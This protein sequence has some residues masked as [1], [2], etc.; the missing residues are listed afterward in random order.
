MKIAVAM[1]H[2]SIATT[3]HTV[4]HWQSVHCH[5]IH[6]LS[7]SIGIQPTS[8]DQ[9][10]LCDPPALRDLVVVLRGVDWHQLGTQLPVPREKLNKID[11][12][13]HDT[14]RKLNETL[15]YWLK[16]DKPS[17]EKVIEALE[18]IGD[19]RN[20]VIE[21]RSKYCRV[22]LNSLTSSVAAMSVNGKQ[23]MSEVRLTNLSI[24]CILLM[25]VV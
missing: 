25:R 5:P 1:M 6:I 11:E 22:P 7:A 2:D 16:N 21:L 12:E 18:R 10:T 19:H 3:C 20:L 13:C 4:S 9:P 14:P 17:W 15:A 8:C 23:L 24:Y